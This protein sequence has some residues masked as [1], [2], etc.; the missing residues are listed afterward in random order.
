METGFRRP[1]PVQSQVIPCII[2]KRNVLVTAPTGTGKTLSFLIP[3]LHTAKKSK[4]IKAVILVPLQELASQI[5]H[6]LS[7]LSSGMNDLI[8]YRCASQINGNES[9]LIEQNRSPGFNILVTTP[10]LFI[11]HFQGHHKILKHV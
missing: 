3:I 6:E 9:N 8:S 11:Q 2:E 4:F 10:M 5:I 1:T 7:I